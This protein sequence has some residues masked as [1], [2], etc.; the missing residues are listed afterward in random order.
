MAARICKGLQG[1]ARGKAKD[2]E[3]EARA[4]KPEQ[5]AR[6]KSQTQSKAVSQKSKSRPFF[7]KNVSESKNGSIKSCWK[8]NFIY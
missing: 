3:Q 2:P 6:G 8:L 5:E 1:K 7:N 4:K